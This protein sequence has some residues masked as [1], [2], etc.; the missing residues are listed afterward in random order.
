MRTLKKTRALLHPIHASGSLCKNEEAGTSCG[1]PPV[2]TLFS[3]DGNE[4][5]VQLSCKHCFHDQCVRG[6]TMVSAPGR[7][8]DGLRRMP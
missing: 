1:C 5:V 2:V 8:A 4:R 3:Q 7:N 6:W